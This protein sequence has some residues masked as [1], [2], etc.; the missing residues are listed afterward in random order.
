MILS[1]SRLFI[2]SPFYEQDEVLHYLANAGI[3]L[4]RSFIPSSCQDRS[5]RYPDLHYHKVWHF[6]STISVFQVTSALFSTLS[7]FTFVHTIFSCPIQ[8]IYAFPSPSHKYLNTNS[9]SLQWLHRPPTDPCPSKLHGCH[10]RNNSQRSHHQSLQK[11]NP[12]LRPG[13]IRIR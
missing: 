8:E 9:L 10:P 1:R 3:C 12:H 5:P 4:Q 2:S 6:L 7:L 13:H 11:P